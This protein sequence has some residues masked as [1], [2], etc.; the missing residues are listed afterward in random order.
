MII[1]YS[2]RCNTANLVMLRSERWRYGLEAGDLVLEAKTDYLY[3][4]QQIDVD[5][6]NPKFNSLILQRVTQGKPKYT[7]G[8]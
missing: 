3:E 2:S 5:H 7:Y 4:I 1:K 8:A 6:R